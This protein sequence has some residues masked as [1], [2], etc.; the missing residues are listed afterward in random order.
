MFEAAQRILS[1]RGTFL[2]ITTGR[3]I[4]RKNYEMLQSERLRRLVSY[5]Y[6]NVEMYRK[7]YDG[8]GVKPGDIKSI[9]DIYKL[10]IVTKDDL[11]ENYPVGLL[12]KRIRDRDC[13]V[14]STTGTTGEPVKV[15]KRKYKTSDLMMTAPLALMML[16]RIAAIMRAEGIKRRT[17]AIVATDQDCVTYSTLRELQKAPG[18]IRGSVDIVNSLDE[19]E[20]HIRALQEYDPHILISYPGVLRSVAALARRTGV[21][22]PQPKLL[23]IGGEL[24]DD[25]TSKAISDAFKGK[26]VEHYGATEVGAVALG[27]PQE[28]RL[29]IM[30][31]LSILEV[32]H[33][34]K[35]VPPGVPGNAVITDL[36]NMATPMIRYSGLDDVLV[37]GDEMCPCGSKLPVIK[38][39]HGRTVDSFVLADGSL[40]HP[41][42]LIFALAHIPEIAYYQVVQ[43]QV[44]RVRVLI[45]AEGAGGNSSR[46]DEGRPLWD[47]IVSRIKKPLGEDIHVAIEVVADIPRPPGA[48]FYPVVRSLVDKSSIRLGSS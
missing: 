23:V 24:M 41:G 27:C 48:R 1:M 18:F 9:A 14:V 38:V 20:A 36:W 44:D 25:Y 6:E 26:I 31:M 10:P 19:P 32:V 39:V 5:A 11:R 35:P 42:R 40:I 3:G 22:L 37:L 17:L 16:P 47:T 2:D 13:F 21:T 8:A 4:D 43:E 12:S 15:F 28:G 33:D 46:F 29:H 30:C 7:K 45:V 34:G